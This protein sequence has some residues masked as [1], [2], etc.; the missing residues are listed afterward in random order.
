MN[1][2][3]ASLAGRIDHALLAPTMTE[4]EMIEGCRVAAAYR[5]ASVCIKPHAIPLAVE[6]LAGSGVKVC[7]VIGFPHGAQST[8][9]KVAETTEAIDLGATEVDVVVNIGLVRSARWSMV[10]DEINQLSSVA[11]AKGAMIKVIFE[12]C[13]LDQEQKRRLCE[14]AS[15][16]GV[17]WV[18]TSTGFGTGGATREDVALMLENVPATVQVKASG[19]IKDLKTAREFASMGCTRLGLSRTAEILDDLAAEYGTTPTIVSRGTHGNADD[20]Y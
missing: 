1:A 14:I 3:D 12:T 16:A 11:H 15:R 17:D 7:T 4:A 13:Y 2:I 20:R 5:V 18:K 9:I 8:A 10:D 19:G 6:H